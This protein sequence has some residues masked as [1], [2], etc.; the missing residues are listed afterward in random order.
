GALVTK[1]SAA[2]AAA[3]CTLG[4]L[5]AGCLLPADNGDNNAD[6]PETSASALPP[7]PA[8]HPSPSGKSLE[9]AFD[10]D[11]MEDYVNAVL[12]MIE[13]WIKST[14]PGMSIPQVEYV[15]SGVQGREGCLDVNGR[16]AEYTS[17]SYEYCPN[18]GIVYVGQDTLWEFYT[19]TGDAG[20]AM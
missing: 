14:W 7:E 19:K 2:L 15:A 10:Y 3:L 18:D 6:Q 11:H 1:R 4:L 20:P 17:E 12:G 9:G 5:T 16:R 13:P 8:P